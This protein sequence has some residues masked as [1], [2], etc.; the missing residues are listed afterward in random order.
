MK[1]G[2]GVLKPVF[3]GVM[4][5][6]FVP[7]LWAAQ[8]PFL[9]LNTVVQTNGQ[10]QFNL[11][12]EDSVSY[13]IEGSSDLLNWT[14]V[15]TNSDPSATRTITVNGSQNF[16]F[17]R[18]SR[19]PLPLFAGAITAKTSITLNGNSIF[20]DSYDSSD[21]NLFPGGIYYSSNRMDHGD[22]AVGTSLLSIGNADIMGTVWIDGTVLN[23]E[24]A[25][26]PDGAVG[27]VPFVTGG[28]TGLESANF[29]VLDF[30][31]CLPDVS[32]PFT[33]GGAISPPALGTTNT[34]TTG[35]Y[36][37]N[38]N[39]SIPNS[40]AL[41]IAPYSYVILYVT[42]NFSM[43]LASINIQQGGT[44]LLYV[45]GSSTTFTAMNNSGTDFNFQYYGL[46]ANTNITFGANGTY[47]GTFYAPEANI[48]ISGG[49]STLLDFSGAFVAN[50]FNV[51]GHVNFHYDENLA[52]SGPQR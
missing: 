30:R 8:D 9:T 34:L 51:N 44:L 42:G 38:G 22:V 36:Y 37:Y 1:K 52:R 39:F 20:T 12:G 35:M 24:S 10:L 25:I 16:G 14:P 33:S 32:V 15:L 19:G 29:A 4:A 5:F 45:G 6:A 41:Q 50:S 13:V 23:V 46:P 7:C 47:A 49:G 11:N 17:Y 40:A 28:G 2:G 31:F 27:D 26:G 48:K 18:A 3:A 43:S 21:T